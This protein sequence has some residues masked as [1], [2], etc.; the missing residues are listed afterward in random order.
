MASSY[1]KNTRD[2]QVLLI[3]AMLIISVGVYFISKNLFFDTPN[4]QP[5]AS[6]TIADKQ[7]GVPTI[8]PDILLQKIQ[9]GEKIAMVDIR[10]ETSFKGEHIKNA[11]SLS[12]SS[13][14]N[15]TPAKD[16]TVVIVFSENDP[17]VF[18]TA[19]NIMREKSFAYFFLA[20]GFEGWKAQSAPTVSVGDPN[21]FLDQSKITYIKS[22]EY[23]KLA[24]ESAAPIFI[25]DVQTEDSFKK[26][27]LKGAVNIPLNLLEKRVGEIPAGRQIVV[28]GENSLASFRGGV[29]LSDLGI[30]TA[31]TLEGDT[32]LS[33]ESGLP[34][35]P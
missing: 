25:L 11:F 30:F 27:H 35:E 20:G 7:K 18:D 5:S 26:K 16:E 3:G 4:I 22:E 8:A 2:K 13:L 33:P 34:L 12:I 28:Y 19:K 21:S 31:R 15:F 23:K 9:S 10:S 24:S 32:H 1:R 14:G 29:R 17:E 6:G